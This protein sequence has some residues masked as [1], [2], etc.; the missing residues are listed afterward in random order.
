MKRVVRLISSLV[1]GCRLATTVA[2]LMVGSLARAQSVSITGALQDPLAG[3]T[4]CCIP[5]YSGSGTLDHFHL[6]CTVNSTGY[7]TGAY[8]SVS[9]R[10]YA[11]YYDSSNNLITGTDNWTSMGWTDVEPFVQAAGTNVSYDLTAIENPSQDDHGMVPSNAIYA[12][13]GIKVHVS[14]WNSAGTVKYDDAEW[15]TCNTSGNGIGTGGV[16]SFKIEVW[17]L[18]GVAGYYTINDIHNPY[19]TWTGPLTYW[20]G[21]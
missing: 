11:E 2:A 3:N 16:G 15:A 17:T 20:G 8:T 13:Y 4:Y 1:G 14:L 19:S 9:V 10:M 18:A 12:V 5:V 21:N 6:K 7:P